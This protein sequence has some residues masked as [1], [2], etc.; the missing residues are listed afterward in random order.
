MAN[1]ISNSI[2]NAYNSFMKASDSLNTDK[3][4]NRL[5]EAGY[6]SG[7]G[8]LGGF[9]A[10]AI[11]VGASA[12]GTAVLWQNMNPVD[13][14]INEMPAAV[15]A[16]TGFVHQAV[17]VGGKLLEAGA[18]TAVIALTANFGIQSVDAVVDMVKATRHASIDLKDA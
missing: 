3:L 4:A 18:E 9:I 6:N 15:K 14:L 16:Q 5:V 1:A 10:G 7:A 12:G 8:R 11:G 13:T 17:E 2:G